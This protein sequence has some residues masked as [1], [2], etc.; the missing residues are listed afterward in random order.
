VAEN[1]ADELDDYFIETASFDEVLDRK[2]TIFIGRKGTGKT[3]NLLQAK[4]R[5]ARDKRNLVC[6]MKPF[7]YEL[8]DVVTLMQRYQEKADL[9]YL[10]ESLW[11]FLIYSEIAN[12]AYAEIK[13]RPAGPAPGSPDE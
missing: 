11:K 1:E 10:I 2:T 12:A 6:V 5:L 3:A 9:G 7:S 4:A 13:Q 8:D